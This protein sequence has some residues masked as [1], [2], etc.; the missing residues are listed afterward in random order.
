M[1]NHFTNSKYFWLAAISKHTLLK[2][3]HKKARTFEEILKRL[4]RLST[5]FLVFLLDVVCVCVR[6]FVMLCLG[7]KWKC[8][9]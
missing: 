2:N 4:K 7:L 9:V 6:M 8:C 1:L 3:A 5:F